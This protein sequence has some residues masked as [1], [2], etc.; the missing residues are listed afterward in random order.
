PESLAPEK[1]AKSA[2][3]MANPVASLK[4]LQSHK[5]LSGLAIALT[6]FYLAHNA[7]PTV[8]AVYTQQRYN[9]GPLQIGLSLTCVGV[10]AAIVS[11][12]LVGRYVKKFGERFSVLTGLCYGV[13]GF[14]GFAIA[15]RGWMVLAAIPF[16]AL[17]GVAGPAI[18]SIMSRRVDH[19]SQGKL[20]GA[21]NSLRSI[22]Q[23][24]APVM[25][26]QIFAYA[27]SPRSRV[28]LPGAPYFLSA[29]LLTTS[30]LVAA[31][32]LRGY[33]SAVIPSVGAPPPRRQPLAELRLVLTPDSR[34]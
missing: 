26:T 12:G 7:L 32:V 30:M 9:W 17:W 19:S 25:F 21:I 1:R 13:L 24:V 23:M 15:W 3:H 27:I 20:Q 2:L 14:L 29:V 6:I 8:W 22:T 34:L 28:Y 18:Q 5:E 10:C 16:I 31:W 11:G 4:L 33:V